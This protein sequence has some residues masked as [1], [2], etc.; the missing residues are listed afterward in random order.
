MSEV[1]DLLFEL[2]TEEL[3]PKSLKALAA[4]LR[5]NVEKGLTQRGL[6]HGE[7]SVFAT[8]R[9]LATLV[10]DLAAVQND[11]IIERRGPALNVAYGSDGTA[12]K[13]TLGFA[14][15]CGVPVD[16]L[17]VIHTDRGEWVGFQQHLKGAATTELLPDV[18]RQALAEL[19]IAKRMRWGSGDA[20]FVRPVQWVVLLFGDTVVE[21]EILGVTTGR[22][23]RG[24]RFHSPAP[25]PISAPGDYEKA[26]LDLG[27]IMVSFENRKEAIES[28]ARKAAAGVNGRAHLDPDLL[29]E[30]TALVEWPIPVLG[31]FD[32]RYLTLPPEVLITTMQENQ[33]YFPVEDHAGGL[34]PYFI[35]FSNLDSSNIDTVREG[36]ERVIVPRLS[37]AEFFWNQDRRKTLDSRVTDLASVTYQKTLGSLLDKT[38]R[39]QKLAVTIA[40]DLEKDS[41][42]A[43]RAAWLAKADLLTEMVGEFPTLQGVMGRY[44][45]LAE[46]EPED[47]AR[48]IEEHYQPRVSGGPLPVT[49]SGQILALA[50]KCDTVAGIFSTGLLPTGDRDPFGLR[51]ATLGMIRILLEK[52]LDLDVRS[53]LERALGL[54]HHSFDAAAT[55]DAIFE[56]VLE[57][58]RG[59]FLE[60]GYQS[61]EIESVLSL[62]LTRPLDCERRLRAVRDFRGLTAADSLA[63]ANKR[64]R[65]LLR[66]S[67]ETIVGNVDENLL[68]EP[69][70]VQLFEA[71]RRAHGDVLPLLQ[72]CDYAG[73]LSRLAQLREP[74][75]AFFDHVLVMAEDEALRRNRLGLLALIEHLFID[76]ADVGKLQPQQ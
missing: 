14:R 75:D 59:H 20:E 42:S 49:E 43:Q 4:S 23:T 39:L 26:L 31:R 55:L 74:A 30:V 29:D 32:E 36:N 46:G 54:F 13:A 19:P 40:E 63:A 16:E 73:A 34:L 68:R 57:R 41:A 56:F 8:P 28:L 53:V 67:E 5:D 44:Y 70:E 66:K 71:A 27:K 69:Q 52:E 37:D 18:F 47:V 51:R 58:L 1:C 35:T 61:D 62:K 9:R 65:N 22:T 10:R 45:S 17:T 21:A 15:S 76:I 64:I 48:A 24:H 60:Q 38:R 11:Q 72:R 33:K 2:G 3:P 7:V 25:F 50:E 6:E 12:T